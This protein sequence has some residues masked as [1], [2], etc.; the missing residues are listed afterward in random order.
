MCDKKINDNWD[1]IKQENK[2]IS[3]DDAFIVSSYTYEPKHMYREY[4]P[5]RLLNTNLVSNDRKSGIINV[6]KYLF[7]FLRALRRMKLSKKPFYTGASHAK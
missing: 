3:K 6:E 7:L 2:E 5:Y 4:S 1:L